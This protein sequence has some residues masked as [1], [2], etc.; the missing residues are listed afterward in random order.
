VSADI[1]LL[2]RT[3][4]FAGLD[5]AA[6]E[7]VAVRGVP[8]SFEPGE[9]LYSAGADPDRCWLITAGLVDLLGAVGGVDAAEVV[10]RQRKGSSVGEVAVIL[11]EPYGET[12]V[13]S[14][15]TSALQ[16]GAREMRQLAEEF[17]QIMVNVLRTIHGRLAYARSRIA[18][19]RQGETV[20]VVVGASLRGTVGRLIAAAR[21]TSP[22]PVTALDRQFSFAGAVTAAEDLAATHATVLLPTELDAATVATLTREADRV[23]ALAGTASEV[24][25]L[26]LLEGSGET[27]VELVPVSDEAR[28][29]AK[30][31]RGKGPVRVVHSCQTGRGMRLTDADLGWLAR[32]LTRTKIGL[33]LGAG[34]AKGYAHVGVLQVLE[35]AGYVVDCVAGSSIG[36]IVGTYLALGRDAAQI[37]RTL[38]EL[39]IPANVAEIFKTSLSGRASGLELMTQLMQETTNGKSFAD[40]TI[41]LTVMSVDLDQRAPAPLQDGPLWEALLAATALAGVF[42]PHQRDGHRLVDGLAL[43]PVPTGAVIEA[44]ADV[45]VSV[46]L[47]S[48]EVLPRWPGGPPPEPPAERRRRG[49][50]DDL[51]EV[52]DLSQLDQSVRH[53]ELADVP[54]TPRFGPGQWRDFHLADL[55]LAAGRAAAERRLPDLKSLALPALTVEQTTQEGGGIDRADAVRL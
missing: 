14:I 12:V 32:H 55:Y 47:I 40:T 48:A 38:R 39:F 45:T 25:E 50:L 53:A 5:A 49:V 35:E 29:A 9:E 22:R 1:A 36:A 28:T 46:N 8:R 26:D 13:A 18:Q 2:A 16:L 42:P 34:G 27:V 51:L 21:A 7:V 15:R 31:L 41:P 10:A 30:A 24:A 37:E 11:G 43:V 4:M 19:A 33:A 20:A 52:M 44:G 3:P 17:P 23:V 6:L 54:V